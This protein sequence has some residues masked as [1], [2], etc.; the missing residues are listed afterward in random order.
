[1]GEIGNKLNH[2]QTLKKEI[3]ER[4]EKEM[5]NEDHYKDILRLL[6]LEGLYKVSYRW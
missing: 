3:E 4:V 5:Q 6:I 2:I 1:M